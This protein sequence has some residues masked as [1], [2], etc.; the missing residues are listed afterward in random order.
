MLSMLV[1]I[2]MENHHFSLVNPLFLWPCSIAIPYAPCMEYLPTFALKITHMYANIPYMEHMG[3][4][5]YQRVKTKIYRTIYS[6]NPTWSKPIKIL[7]VSLHDGGST[8]YPT[9]DLN[10]L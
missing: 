8:V 5:V 9:D 10:S 2:T 4:L 7:H 3:M 6:G 1:Y